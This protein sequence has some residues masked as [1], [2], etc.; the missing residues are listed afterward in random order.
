M[1]VFNEK[2]LSRL[3]IKVDTAKKTIAQKQD[4]IDRAN[5][6]ATFY[7][8]HPT[9]LNDKRDLELKLARVDKAIAKLQ[10]QKKAIRKKAKAVS[11]KYESRWL[12]EVIRAEKAD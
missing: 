12:R 2:V 9:L 5:R 10:R 4:E 7:T 3:Q 8:E 6:A 1:T 11:K